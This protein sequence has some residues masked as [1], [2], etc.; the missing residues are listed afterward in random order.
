MYRYVSIKYQISFSLVYNFHLHVLP[1]FIVY[2]LNY[3]Q[4][5]CL[6][7]NE[8]FTFLLSQ[9]L[10][11]QFQP[12][13]TQNIIISILLTRGTNTNKKGNKANMFEVFYI[14]RTN[15]PNWVV[16]KLLFTNTALMFYHFVP[17]RF[18]SIKWMYLLTDKCRISRKC[19]ISIIYTMS[20]GCIEHSFI[21]KS[22]LFY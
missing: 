2:F 16:A 3:C 6:P 15:C 8:S 19:K 13:L 1:N 9:K 5:T 17:N 11:N 18:K 20:F 22:L 21:L 7:V 10:Y 14:L 12:N 4:L